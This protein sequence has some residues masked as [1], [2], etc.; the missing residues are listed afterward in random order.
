MRP[1]HLLL[2]LQQILSTLL[3]LFLQLSFRTFCVFFSLKC[4]L[5]LTLNI[6]SWNKILLETQDLTLETNRFVFLA[7]ES[8]HALIQFQAQFRKGRFHFFD[9]TAMFLFS[10]C[11]SSLILL[12]VFAY[13]ARMI[14]QH[15]LPDFVDIVFIFRSFTTE[16]TQLHWIFLFDFGK[17][18]VVFSQLLYRLRILIC[19]FFRMLKVNLINFAFLLFFLLRILRNFFLKINNMCILYLLYLL[20][21]IFIFFQQVLI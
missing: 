14:S 12:I 19:C 7:I 3:H 18:T 21:I 10:V 16:L 5:N 20:K 17:Q 4:F 2:Q 15:L 9:S 11:S 8:I 6:L 13:L 1:V